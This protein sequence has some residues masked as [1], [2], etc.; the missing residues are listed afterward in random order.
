MPAQTNPI[1]PNVV[2]KLSGSLA[3]ANTAR[4]GTGTITTIITGG[5]NGSIV[6]AIRVRS[7]EAAGVSTPNVVRLWHRP[8]GAGT[9]YMIDEVAL[10][11]AT[12]SATVVGASAVF[13]TLN[14]PLTGTVQ[15]VASAADTLGLTIGASAAVA[16]TADV[17]DY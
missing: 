5:A 7:I 9:W 2:R 13:A 3:T 14:I 16:W 17:V 4:D 15:G 12:P 6:P 10:L 8:A 1:A 11:T